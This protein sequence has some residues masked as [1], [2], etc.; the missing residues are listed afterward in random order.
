MGDPLP[1]KLYETLNNLL[2]MYTYPHEEVLVL[3]AV[4]N[5]IDAH[6]DRINISF[7]KDGND[8]FILF[9]DNGRGMTSEEFE[10]YHTISLSS[11]TKGEGIGFAGVGAKIFLASDDGSEIITITS[12]GNKPLAS[13][14]YR[15]GTKVEYE[16]SER[17]GLEEILDGTKVRSFRG[18]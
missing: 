7:E 6:A 9:Q 18:T 4:A 15:K 12:R 1:I 17:V 14:M 16:T 10:N 3:E 8:R 2:K 5:G 11:K 13:K